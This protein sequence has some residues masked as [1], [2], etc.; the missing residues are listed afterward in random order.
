MF[1]LGN[2]PSVVLFPWSDW[3]TASDSVVLCL[4]PDYKRTV[5]FRMTNTIRLSSLTDWRS[6]DSHLVWPWL[7]CRSRGVVVDLP[8]SLQQWQVRGDHPP[9][10]NSHLA[11]ISARRCPHQHTS[12]A[13]HAEPAHTDTELGPFPQATRRCELTAPL[14]AAAARR[15]PSHLMSVSAH[16]ADRYIG[17]PPA[18]KPVSPHITPIGTTKLPSGVSWRHGS[19]FIHF[20]MIRSSKTLTMVMTK[21]KV[22]E[23]GHNS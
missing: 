23:V 13:A 19:K 10:P 5:R 12:G 20:H 7:E 17:R 9:T 16:S 2:S 14:T 4:R 22:T 11:I 1:R 18:H 8:I 6:E 3:G 21:V 15:Q